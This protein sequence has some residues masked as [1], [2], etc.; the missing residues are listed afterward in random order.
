VAEG[1]FVTKVPDA[2]VVH[3][4]HE[5]ALSTV[6]NCPPAQAVQ[7]RSVVVE[8]S[9]DTDVPAV[10]VDLATHTVAGLP[11]WSQV[12]VAHGACALVPPAQ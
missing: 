8:P 1:V 6:E 7:L 10:Q 11:S 9:L 3:A 2:Q 4:V 5:A 12:L